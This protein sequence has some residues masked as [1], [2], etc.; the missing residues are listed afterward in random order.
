MSEGNLSFSTGQFNSSK[1]TYTSG[2]G[3]LIL[4][5]DSLIR[6]RSHIPE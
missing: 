5:Q 3:T 2:R 6:L 1:V 4:V